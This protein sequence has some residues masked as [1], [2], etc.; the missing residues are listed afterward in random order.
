MQVPVAIVDYGDNEAEVVEFAGG[1]VSKDS[2]TGGRAAQA[3]KQYAIP[4]YPGYWELHEAF[5]S[6]THSGENG[7]AVRRYSFPPI[8]M[9]NYLG[10]SLDTVKNLSLKRCSDIDGTLFL[11]RRGGL[12]IHLVSMNPHPYCEDVHSGL[13]HA[14]GIV[15]VLGGKPD[16]HAAADRV[17]C[18]S[19]CIATTVADVLEGYVACTAARHRSCLQVAIQDTDVSKLHPVDG[20][21]GEALQRCKDA[22]EQGHGSRW[23]WH[24]L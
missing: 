10:Q 17:F 3:S 13:C 6:V 22:V 21:L 5:G 11:A 20:V 2:L 23:E 18:D 14:G 4:M 19:S 15:T 12:Q 24:E 9:P 7:N 8:G 1:Q 16:G